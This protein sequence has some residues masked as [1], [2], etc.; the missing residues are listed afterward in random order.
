MSNQD[1]AAQVIRTWQQRHK[2][3][4]DSTPEWAA[5][6][7]AHDLHD[8]NLIAPDPP[9]PFFEHG[10]GPNWEIPINDQGG[11]GV[12]TVRALGRDVFIER[13]GHGHGHGFITNPAEAKQLAAA[14]LAA[15][16]HQEE[17]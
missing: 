14:I 11:G 10:H 8:A 7:L 17:E 12:A 4:M 15:A 9:Q 2:S 5:Q 1:Q 13:P 16:N 3:S 6:N